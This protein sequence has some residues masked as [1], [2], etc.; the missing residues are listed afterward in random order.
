MASIIQTKVPD[1]AISVYGSSCNDLFLGLIVDPF[2][3]LFFNPSAGTDT[4]KK[5]QEGERM[6]P[7][8]RELHELLYT[9]TVKFE[10]IRLSSGQQFYSYS[11]ELPCCFF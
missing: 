3:S 11:S 5:I 6:R 10:T 1:F 4:K 7:K 2:I 9:E 8:N